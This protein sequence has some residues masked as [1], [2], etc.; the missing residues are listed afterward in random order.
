M[1]SF[2]L[3]TF[4]MYLLAGLGGMAHKNSATKNMIVASFILYSVSYN[5]SAIARPEISSLQCALLY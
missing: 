4:W 3:Q 1:I 5:V 2:F